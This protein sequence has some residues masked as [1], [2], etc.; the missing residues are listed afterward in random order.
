MGAFVLDASIAI[1]WCFPEDPTE[2]T[3][4][5]RQILELLETVDAIVPEIWPFEIAN[6]IFVSFCRR[7][8]VSEEQVKR[9]VELISSL[10]IRVDRR[11]WTATLSLESLARKH[12]LAAYDVAY[13]ELA[14]RQGLSLATTDEGLIKSAQAEGVELTHR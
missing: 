8:R 11:S 1:S 10:P 6:G 13:L 9:Y 3:I 2:N 7:K 12:N 5:S 4:Y 14:K